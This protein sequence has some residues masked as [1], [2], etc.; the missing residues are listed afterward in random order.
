MFQNVSTLQEEALRKWL[1]QMG[2]EVPTPGTSASSSSV[3]IVDDPLRNG[4]LL[5]ALVQMLDP[6]HGRSV[7][8][9]VHRNP[10]STRQ[11]SRGNNTYIYVQEYAFLYIRMQ[12]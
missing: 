6:D 8:S 11:V 5:V 2:F 7:L 12:F 4:T 9:R 3:S 10:I 1:Q